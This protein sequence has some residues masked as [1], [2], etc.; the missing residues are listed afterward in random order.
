MEL[1]KV[2]SFSIDGLGSFPS[3][4]NT[5]HSLLE[6]SRVPGAED[7]LHAISLG[8]THGI[9][10]SPHSTVDEGLLLPLHR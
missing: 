7:P 5:P 4:P 8:P 3:Q 10:A 1:T 9:P 2:G 6:Q